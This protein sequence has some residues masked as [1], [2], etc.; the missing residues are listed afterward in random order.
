MRADAERNRQRVLEAA[1]EVLARDGAAVSMRAVAE[2]AG[3]GLGTIYRH[4]PT[5]E[6]LLQAIVVDR[7]RRLAESAGPLLAADDP[8]AAFFTFFTRVVDVSA[9]KKA[10][11]DEVSGAGLDPKAGLGAVGGQL[12]A[13]IEALLRRAQAAGGVRADLAMPEL[14]ALLGAACLGAERNQWDD[15]LRDRALGLLFDGLRGP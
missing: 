10:L 7:V 9:R 11:A 8:A 1:E 14:L 13:A 2:R 12:R 3:V 5:R 4:F 15:A 6:A